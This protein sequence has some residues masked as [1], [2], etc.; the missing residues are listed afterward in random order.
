MKKRK[1]DE[2]GDVDASLL[3]NKDDAKSIGD[4]TRARAMKYIQSGKK[5]EEIST[6]TPKIEAQTVA[7][8][9]PKTEAKTI[10]KP[11]PKTEI[12]TESTSNKNEKENP[13][14]VRKAYIAAAIMNAK[15]NESNKGE[16]EGKSFS[17]TVKAKQAELDQKK[18]K[19]KEPEKS[20]GKRIREALGSKY[21]S[22]G[23]VAGKLATRGY[24]KSR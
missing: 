10:A 3:S 15:N 8:P 2:G 1:F 11:V 18:P 12:T 6:S 13:D 9:S 7:K 21:S 16:V 22:G 4:D 5:E 23:K 20:I 14:A 24:G 19:P 17:E